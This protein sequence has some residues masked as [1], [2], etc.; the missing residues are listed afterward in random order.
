MRSVVGMR[1]RHL[2]PPKRLWVWIPDPPVALM[3]GWTLL[4]PGSLPH[5]TFW[6]LIR[7]Q[8]CVEFEASAY[9][10]PLLP[11]LSSSGRSCLWETW[12]KLTC[13]AC[14]SKYR[15]KQDPDVLVTI[16]T[17]HGSTS[18]ERNHQFSKQHSSTANFWLQTIFRLTCL[19]E[20]YTLW[21][22]SKLSLIP[23]KVKWFSHLSWFSYLRS[24]RVPN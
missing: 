4:L 22:R 3:V 21:N 24:N 14:R 5:L 10:S 7:F 8:Y 2:S 17:T 20:S 12:N 6:N 9:H 11:L 15:K 16:Y 23:F 18:K 13:H 19:S 1:I